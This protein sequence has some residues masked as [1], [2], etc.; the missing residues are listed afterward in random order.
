VI[1]LKSSDGLI[2][3]SLSLNKNVIA[4]AHHINLSNRLGERGHLAL[5]VVF[6]VMPPIIIHLRTFKY[7][8]GVQD[9]GGAIC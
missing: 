6:C 8:E 9:F 5:E 3:S 4:S 1:N 2:E 7:D